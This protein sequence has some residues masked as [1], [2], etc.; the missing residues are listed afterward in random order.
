MISFAKLKKFL[1]FFIKLAIAGGIVGYLVLRNPAEIAEGFRE[2]NYKWLLPALIVYLSHILVCAW[3][4][5]RLTRLL[6]VELSPFEALSLTMQGNFFS[7]VIP[8]GA[9]G[10]DVVKMGVLSRRSQ[11][12][13]KVEGAFTI[14]MDRIIG[15]IALFSLALILLVPVIPLLMRIQLPQIELTDAM[16]EL[17]IIALAGL[18]LAGLGA[19]CVIFFHRWIEKLPF[20]GT[21]MQK[22]DQLTHGM[23]SRM[24]A[25]TD[26][27]VKKWKSLITLTVASVFFV[28]LMTVA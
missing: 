25:A 27:Y 1:W 4:W 12:G 26:I 19:S 13:S 2:F 11:A 22:G 8:G 18:C 20:F 5:L 9:I 6:E 7:L 16:R 3:R 14:L 24:T 28:H 17:G 10:G 21:L 15:M 23:V